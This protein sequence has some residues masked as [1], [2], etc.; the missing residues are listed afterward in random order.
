MA[1]GQAF[2]PS[3]Q[4]VIGCGSPCFRVDPPRHFRQRWVC[5]SRAILG[6]GVGAEGMETGVGTHTPAADF[7]TPAPARLAIQT[8][9]VT[10]PHVGRSGDSGEGVSHH[11]GL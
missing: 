6:F 3:H 5:L 10:C 7:P 11:L 2:V 4:P 9:P 8:S 1:G